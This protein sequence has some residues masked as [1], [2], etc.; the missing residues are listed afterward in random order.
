MNDSFKNYGFSS[1]I[2]PGYNNEKTPEEYLNNYNKLFPFIHCKIEE[3]YLFAPNNLKLKEGF[4]VDSESNLSVNISDFTVK[5][6][7]ESFDKSKYNY[8]WLVGNFDGAFHKS[9]EYELGLLQF[10]KGC[11]HAFHY[12]DEIFE[13]NILVSGNLLINNVL[14]NPGEMY[15]IPQGVITC[16]IF[17]D[18]CAIICVK[19]PSRPNDKIII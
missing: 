5:L 14:I 9:S 18:D 11:R 3:F 6:A 8:G 17:L 12:H 16:P 15:I 19:T 10:R 1:G 4:L 13:I 7:R 2:L